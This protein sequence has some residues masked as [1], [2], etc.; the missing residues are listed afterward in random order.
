MFQF[1]VFHFKQKVIIPITFAWTK[2]K[3]KIDTA[4]KVSK[5]GVFSDPNAGKYG[6]EKTPYVN[7][8]HAVK[9]RSNLELTIFAVN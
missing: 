4:G 3:K 8:F 6:P 7:T 5:F 2:K 9:K 1:K